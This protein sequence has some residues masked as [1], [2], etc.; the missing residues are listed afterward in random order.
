[1]R[2]FY[3]LL[4]TPVTVFSAS[5][6]TTFYSGYRD[7][8]GAASPDTK[9]GA[10]VTRYSVLNIENTNQFNEYVSK[11]NTAKDNVVSISAGF[12]YH[13]VGGD[14]NHNIIDSAY[15]LGDKEH[16][17]ILNGNGYSSYA[18]PYHG[19]YG[20]TTQLYDIVSHVSYQLGTGNYNN[21]ILNNTQ[22]S[23]SLYDVAGTTF[24]VQYMPESISDVVLND[25]F[26]YVNQRGDYNHFIANGDSTIAVVGTYMTWF[27]DYWSPSFV[28]YEGTEFAMPYTSYDD[29]K[30]EKTDGYGRKLLFVKINNAFYNDK[31]KEIIRGNTGRG[32]LSLPDDTRIPYSVIAESYNSVFRDNS[33]QRIMQM[34]VAHSP[35]FYDYSRM[36]VEEGGEVVD[37]E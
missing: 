17:L 4:I 15:T 1:M 11:V 14:P 2:F 9:G 22:V 8:L 23:T 27:Y 28:Q 3:I 7:Y 24:Y 13:P 19:F 35:K 31:S 32:Y 36:T 26:F 33:S 16:P 30:N 12:T 37:A 34:A 10:P 29:I 5:M 18:P 25:S 6:S 21:V 20:P